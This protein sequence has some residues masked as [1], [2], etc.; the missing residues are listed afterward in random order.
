MNQ[1][2]KIISICK[3]I[4]QDENLLSAIDAGELYL[5]TK[6]MQLKKSDDFGWASYKEIRYKVGDMVVDFTEEPRV[7]TIM[8]DIS[9]IPNDEIYSAGG[10][11][12]Y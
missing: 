6:C 12:R 8:K 11:N 2:K 9:S 4:L 3:I 7:T 1:S 5:C 10:W